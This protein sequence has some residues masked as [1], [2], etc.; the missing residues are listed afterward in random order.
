MSNQESE[1]RIKK[2]ERSP[3]IFESETLI[4][5]ILKLGIFNPNQSN[6]IKVAPESQSSYRWARILYIGNLPDSFQD[7]DLKAA[8]FTSL[9]KAAG[10]LETGNPV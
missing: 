2:K 9:Q 8:L 6:F 5:N 4:E 7:F 3:Q 10:L 1:Y